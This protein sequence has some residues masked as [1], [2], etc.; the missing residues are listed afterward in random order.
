MKERLDLIEREARLLR[1]PQQ[2]NAVNYVHI[3]SAPARDSRRLRKDPGVLVIAERRG[4]NS[5]ALGDFPN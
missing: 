3:I 4:S 5:G 1:E 2:V